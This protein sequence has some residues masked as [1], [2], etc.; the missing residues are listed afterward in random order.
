MDKLPAVMPVDGEVFEA[1]ISWQSLPHTFQPPAIV[2]PLTRTREYLISLQK[3]GGYWEA[4]FEMDVRQAAEYIFLKHILHM[5]D[6]EEERRFLN[7][8]LKKERPGGGWSNYHGGTPDLSTTVTAYYALR[9][10]GYLPEHPVLQRAKEV[11]LSQGG[12]MQSNCFT[13]SY[14]QLFGQMDSDSLPAM[15]VELMLLPK[16]F[17]FN[18]YAISSWSRSIMVPLLMIAALRVKRPPVPGP[19]CDELYPAGC[20][21]KKLPIAWTKKWFT[22]HNFFLFANIFLKCYEKHPIRWLRNKA[23]ARAHMWVASHMGRQGGLCGIFPPMVNSCIALHF[24][25]YDLDHPLIQNELRALTELK[26]NE[27]NSSWMQPCFST[28]WD[29]AWCLK[30]LPELG[31]PIAHPALVKAK[32]F[33]LSKQVGE[34]GDWQEKIPPVPCGG[35]YFE[36]ENCLYP[37]VDDTA[38]V[39][40]ALQPYQHEPRVKKASDKAI[41]WVFAMQCKDGGWASFDYQ[42]KVYDCFNYIPFADHGALLDPPTADVTARVMEALAGWGYTLSDPNI[43]RASDWLMRDQ[44]PD[45]SWYGRWGVNYI[46]GTWAVLCGLHAAGY[47]MKREP[48]H[49]AV[50]WLFDHQR[51]DGGWGESCASYSNPAQKGAGESTASQTAWALMALEAAGDCQNPAVYKGVH[52]LLREQKADGSWDEEFSTGTGFPGVC[53][54]RYHL[55]RD[56]FPALALSRLLPKVR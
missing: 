53:Y 35:W 38:A 15:P 9:L 7:Y 32:E 49:K 28:I 3:E 8:I 21:R 50:R 16:W 54:L 6:K 46:Y 36:M 37:D 41:R 51:P 30:I 43:R 19:S 40:M 26:V 39:L 1:E 48:V 14:L 4:L 47:D 13:R 45:G 18:I 22:W 5:A 12:I 33:L 24:L 27:G 29:T 11:I 20:N 34:T 10:G 25:G 42:G 56:H 44:K 55:Y 17:P 31:V 52:Y 2:D 23:M